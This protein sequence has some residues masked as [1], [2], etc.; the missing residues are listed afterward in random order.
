MENILANKIAR[1]YPHVKKRI[2][3]VDFIRGLC[4]LLM[5]L[6]HF[7]FDW[8]TLMP[9]IFGPIEQPAWLVELHNFAYFWWTWDVRFI[10]RFIVVAL[11]FF[12]S[13][14][15]TSFSRS[16][17]KRGSIYFTIGVL[18]SC[19]TFDI[20]QINPTIQIA[21]IVNTIFTF[22][23][24]TLLFG[25]FEYL[26]KKFIKNKLAF[27]ITCALL[28]LGIIIAGYTSPTFFDNSATLEELNFSSLITAI[29]GFGRLNNQADYMP[30]FPYLG[31]I[32]L[33]ASFASIFYVDKKSLLQPLFDKFNHRHKDYLDYVAWLPI[34]IGKGVSFVGRYAFLTYIIHQVILIIISSIIMLS[35]GY[36]FNI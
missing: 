36:S 12:L 8:C 31:F 13:G 18:I 14:I 16:N 17:I 20:S 23:L 33:G 28:G 10:T 19:L 1:T 2:F 9:Y 35:L 26:F 32:F 5:I 21:M 3:E 24:A 34:K 25:I 30:L 15:S 22:G 29:V 7:F 4:I 11:F 27:T 6:D